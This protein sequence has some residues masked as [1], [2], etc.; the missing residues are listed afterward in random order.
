VTLTAVLLLAAGTYLFR[1]SG[2][3]LRDRIELSDPARERLALP[4][5]ALLAALV[6]TAALYS[7][8]EFGGWARVT[9]VGV[10]AVLAVRRLPF[11]V[12]VTAAAVVTAVLRALGVP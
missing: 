7:A 10:A 11:A 3:L 2:P 4:A 1:V 9:G 12:V 8:T 6:A 5:V